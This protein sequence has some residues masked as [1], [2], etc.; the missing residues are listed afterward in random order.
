MKTDPTIW[1]LARAT[2]ILAYALLTTTVLAG[3]TARSRPLKKLNAAITVD[4]HRFMSLLALL[5]TGLHGI[6]LTLDT[7]EPIPI[8][9]LL[10]PGASPYRPVWVAAGVLAA[11]VMI[12]VHLSFR[13]RA[14]IG[15]KNW[16]R[17]HYVTYVAFAGATG[18]GLLAGTDSARPWALAMYVAATGA[19]AALTAWR[20]TTPP[21]KAS[22]KAQGRRPAATGEPLPASAAGRAGAGARR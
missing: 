4:V 19:I 18:H 17:L 3:L 8:A 2:G 16:R 6:L 12:L 13:F 14:R 10:V 15:V 22:P 7:A 20:I 9:A 21:R 11:E 5:A 1:I